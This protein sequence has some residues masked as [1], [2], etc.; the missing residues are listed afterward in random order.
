M[1]PAAVGIAPST[2]TGEEIYKI[3]IRILQILQHYSL[4][5]RFVTSLE[6][7]ASRTALLSRSLATRQMAELRWKVSWVK[8]RRSLFIC[9]ECLKS[10]KKA[11]YLVQGTEN[12]MYNHF[13][14]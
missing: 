11:P 12:L 10:N 6:A 5:M 9:L 7:G 4:S 2:V 3:G 8:E 14:N 1:F 13:V